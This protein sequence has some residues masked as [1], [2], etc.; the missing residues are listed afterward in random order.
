MHSA[1]VCWHI[2][3]GSTRGRCVVSPQSRRSSFRPS[4]HA[5]VCPLY[6]AEILCSTALLPGEPSF[7]Q[8]DVV[9]VN[10]LKQINLMVAPLPVHRWVFSDRTV[11]ECYIVFKLLCFFYMLQRVLTP[12]LFC[13]KWHR[14]TSDLIWQPGKQQY[15]YPNYDF[16]AILATSP[17]T[18]L[19]SWIVSQVWLVLDEVM[20]PQNFGALVRSAYFLGEFT[21]NRK[22]FSAL[23]LKHPPN[24]AFTHSSLFMVIELCSHFYHWSTTAMILGCFER[25]SSLSHS[26]FFIHI[27]SPRPVSGSVGWTL[28]GHAAHMIC[29]SQHTYTLSLRCNQMYVACTYS[30]HAISFCHMMTESVVEAWLSCHSMDSRPQV[31]FCN[32]AVL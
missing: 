3:N 19:S 28:S 20:D 16:S 25:A 15:S 24:R 17:E 21:T 5:T 6:A 18:S 12:T 13:L 2:G 1:R 27:H 26:F 32:V 9:N 10:V 11:H 14:G 4:A 22:G 23:S 31:I 29:M 7:T 30:S 8:A